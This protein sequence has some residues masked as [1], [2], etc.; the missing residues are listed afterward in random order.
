MALKQISL[1]FK[2]KF[3]LKNEKI[4]DQPYWMARTGQGNLNFK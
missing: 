3:F 4:V 1:F 2:N